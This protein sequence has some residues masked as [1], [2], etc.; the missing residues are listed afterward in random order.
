VRLSKQFIGIAV[1]VAFAACMATTGPASAIPS[2]TQVEFKIQTLTDDAI[3]F[4]S[5]AVAVIAEE[6]V[7]FGL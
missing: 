6:I 1:A 5:Y 7:Y 2:G 3:S 4:R